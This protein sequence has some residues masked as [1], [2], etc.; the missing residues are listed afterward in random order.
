MPGFRTHKSHSMAHRIAVFPAGIAGVSLHRVY[1][2]V[3]HL[4]HDPNVIRDAI[5]PHLLVIPI[6]EDQVAGMWLIVTILPLS[7][8]SKAVPC[9]IGF[10]ADIAQLRKGHRHDLPVSCSKAV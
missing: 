9:P 8:A 10:A 5:L 2:T 6:K 1:D 7:L 3:F 4:L